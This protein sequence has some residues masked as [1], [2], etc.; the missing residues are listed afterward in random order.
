M[1]KTKHWQITHARTEQSGLALT[2]LLSAADPNWQV[3]QQILFDIQLYPPNPDQQ[4]ALQQVSAIVVTSQYAVKAI[5]DLVDSQLQQKSWFAIGHTTAQALAEIGITATVPAQH[6]SEGLLAMTAL[7]T[8][9]SIA[10][11]KGYAGRDLLETEL[12]LH[13]NVSVLALYRRQWRNLNSATIH[14]FLSSDILIFTSGEMLA[15]LYNSMNNEQK[16][17]LIDKNCLLVSA[18]VQQLAMQLGF[19]QTANV[20]SANNQVLLQA[21]QGVVEQYSSFDK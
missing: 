3:R 12:A 8:A 11:L 1:N 13:S 9:P 19:T 15:H 5:A 18:R 14:A 10:I 4:L 17:Q 16:A 7:T 6:N 20:G 2:N 21:V